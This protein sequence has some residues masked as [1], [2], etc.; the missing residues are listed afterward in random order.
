[1]N[2]EAVIASNKRRRRASTITLDGAVARIDLGKGHVAVIDASDV[3]LVQGKLWRP[4]QMHGR[5]YAVH[6][7]GD[8]RS[9]RKLYLHEAILGK[10]AGQDIDHEDGD[11]LNNRRQNLR[12][13][14]KRQ[15]QQNRHHV[16]GVS[17]F[18]GV[19]AGRQPGSWKS[20]IRIEGKMTHLGTFYD[21]EAAARAYDAAARKNFGQFARCN[22]PI[23]KESM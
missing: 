14:T 22:F 16:T 21:E 12:R 20:H 11:G 9:S 23:D 6:S 17:R 3:S 5:W 10:C 18:K 13:A 7:F 1:M 2:R 19:Y 8:R 4:I 15:N